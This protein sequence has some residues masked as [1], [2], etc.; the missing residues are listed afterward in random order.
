MASKSKTSAH[1][2]F[3]T[4]NLKLTIIYLGVFFLISLFFSYNWY[5]ASTF[6]LDAAANR[7]RDF[8][9]DNTAL[10]PRRYTNLLDQREQELAEAKDDILKS[11]VYSNLLL[12]VVGGLGAYMLADRTLK[13]IKAAHDQQSHFTANASHQLKTPLTV[14]RSEIEVALRQK[15][16]KPGE[17]KQIL[18]S[19]LEEIDKLQKLSDSLLALAGTQDPRTLTTSNEDL[20]PIIKT[21]IQKHQIQAKAANVKIINQLKGKPIHIIN[22]QLFSELVS[23]LIDNAIKHS[24]KNG[25]ITI[26]YRPSTSQ[27]MIADEGP[28]IDDYEKQRVFDRFYQTKSSQQQG[29]PGYGL[30][31]SLAKQIAELHKIKLSIADNSPRGSIFIIKF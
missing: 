23:I 11:I 16:I 25:E 10:L 13:P 19:N 17:A 9:R 21:V 26:K 4:A 29:S 15:T 6:H 30:G 22:P 7:Q 20:R 27:L 31:L 12:L 14:M 3:Q 24:P 2:L 1:K 18:G 5:Q 28:G 8:L